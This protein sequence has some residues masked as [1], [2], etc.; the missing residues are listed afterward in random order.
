M[1]KK[2]EVYWLARV[3]Y[4]TITIMFNHQIVS[5]AITLM[6]MVMVILYWL[7]RVTFDTITIMFTHQIV[8]IIITL[9][10]MVILL[11]GLSHL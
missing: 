10:V 6:I 3:T 9:M 5:I 1:T 11:A 4:G 2:F 7:A 8:T